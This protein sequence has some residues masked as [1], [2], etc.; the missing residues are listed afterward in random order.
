M[1]IWL[2][3]K[4]GM[5]GTCILE[6]LLKKFPHALI[7]SS[8]KE[9]DLTDLESLKK[10]AQNRPITHII[11]AAAYTD[12]ARAEEEKEKAFAVNGQGLENLTAVA[13]DKK[14]K[15]VHVSTDYVFN[16]KKEKPYLETDQTDPLNVYGKSKLLGEKIIQQRL[17]DFLIV[18][19]SWLFAETGRNFVFNVLKKMQQE[20][21]L[22]MVSDQIGRPT[23][24]FDL[25]SA[26]LKL[27]NCSGIF[28]VSGEKAVSWYQFA[29][30]IFSEAKRQ[31]IYM[32]AESIQPVL[33]S[34]FKTK[35]K[36]PFYSVLDL[37][38]TK[39]QLGENFS[40]Y[41]IALQKTVKKYKEQSLILTD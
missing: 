1:L 14:A 3:G 21:C 11:N 7:F 5:L 26:I 17:E 40:S 24:A 12:V 18:R 27:L 23:F 8:K 38:K 31:N 39:K 35:V 34:M 30:D 41:K 37:E 20:K 33:S 2:L 10:I 19:T 28:H 22:N 29:L 4:D 32:K 25:A 16:G 6:L 36:R 15:L 9:A 13:K